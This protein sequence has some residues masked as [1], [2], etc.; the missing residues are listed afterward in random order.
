[1]EELTE[2]MSLTDL[3]PE[4]LL[5]CLLPLSARARTAASASCK[6]FSLLVDE[7]HAEAAHLITLTHEPGVMGPSRSLLASARA[8]DYRVRFPPNVGILLSSKP[9]HLSVLEELVHTL[10][11]QLH[12]IG[13]KVANVFVNPSV[14]R[15]QCLA[16]R[17]A[18][19]HA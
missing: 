15:L 17:C 12:L 19:P 13:A 8:M 16:A 18:A 1:M 7:I 14:S 2:S 11:P 9:I 6:L 5:Q 4:L 3:D 10:P